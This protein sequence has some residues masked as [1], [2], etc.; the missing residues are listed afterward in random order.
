MPLCLMA[1]FCTAAISFAVPYLGPGACMPPTG[2]T[3]TTFHLSICLYSGTAPTTCDL[4]LDDA[5]YPMTNVGSGMMGGMIYAYDTKLAAGT[6]RFRFQFQVGDRTMYKPGP[7]ADAWYNY[8]T[9]VQA[10]NVIS[11]VVKSGAGVPVAMV[12]VR[13]FQGDVAKRL[14]YT[15][16][17]GRY[18]FRQVPDGAWTVKPSRLNQVF[19]PVSRDITVPPSV[20]NADFAMASAAPTARI[21]DGRVTPI[22]GNTQTVFTYAVLYTDPDNREPATHT[23]NIDGTTTL[24]MTKRD[25]TDTDYTDGCAYVATTTLAAGLHKFRFAFSVGDAALL[26]P[27][28]TETN[29]FMGPCVVTGDIFVISGVIAAGLSPLEGVEVTVTDAAG[30][31]R[32]A[33]TMSMGRYAVVGLPAGTYTVRPTLTGYAFDPPEQTVTVGPSVF[34]CNFAAAAQ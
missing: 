2:D 13:L 28:P 14:T 34:N 31:V 12:A 16:M 22:A 26:L 9:V 8:P 30:A 18:C 21:R 25:E 6:H 5:T 19:D 7:T 27:G 10:G 15:N 11:G 17:Q 24:T 1:V 23:V 4:H 32:T 3:N 33:R 29:Y 20:T